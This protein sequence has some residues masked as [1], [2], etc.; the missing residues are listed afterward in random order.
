MLICKSLM[1]FTSTSIDYK[2]C[3]EIIHMRNKNLIFKFKRREKFI[4]NNPIK[5]TRKDMSHNNVEVRGQRVSLC[6]PL[7]LLKY[8][9]LSPYF[10]K[11][12]YFNKIF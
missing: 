9:E 1:Y 3:Q 5:Q 7:F 12:F 8:L 11:I 4:I 6:I 10:I 2:V